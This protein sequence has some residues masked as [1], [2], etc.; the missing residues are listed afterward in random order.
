MT[1]KQTSKTDGDLNPSQRLYEE[2]TDFGRHANPNSPK[3][4]ADTDNTASPE[5]K[6]SSDNK[7]PDSRQSV[8]DGE[9]G[10]SFYKSGAG[11]QKFSGASGKLGPGA[12]KYGPTGGMVGLILFAFVGVGGG[13]TFL[14]GSLLINLKEVF[15]NDRSDATRTNRIFSRATISNAFR[16]TK[17]KATKTIG[18]VRKISTMSKERIKKFTE[19]GFTI[20]GDEIDPTTGKK[21]GSIQ[22]D[23][24]LEPNANSPPTDIV[25][26]HP[27][28]RG[29]ISEIDYPDGHSSVSGKDYFAH[30]D[31]NPSTLSEAEEAFPSKASFYLNKFF[32]K[33]LGKFGFSKKQKDFPDT[34][35]KHE[36]D[37]A[38]DEQTEEKAEVKDGE[39]PTVKEQ[40]DD[41]ESSD[42]RDHS[43]D[44]DETVDTAEE[45]AK[46]KSQ[47]SDDKDSSSKGNLL[48][49]FLQGVCSA[50]R[51]SNTI[52]AGVKIYHM[53]RLADFALMFLQAAD[54]IK[55]GHG[56]GPK[57]EYLSD[58][59]TSYEHNPTNPDGTPNPKYNL[60][61][62]DSD[63]YKT[64]AH[65]DQGALADF[66]KAF[67][68]GGGPVVQKT[69]IGKVDTVNST[70]EKAASKVPGTSGSGRRSM[71]SFCR[72]ANGN[73]GQ[74]IAQCQGVVQTGAAVGSE[75]GPLDGILEG[76]GQYM[77]ACTV[78]SMSPI[79]SSI[80]TKV[81]GCSTVQAGIEKLVSEAAST[82]IK[83]FNLK[84]VLLNIFSK[85][86]VNASTRGVDAGNA[87]AA[88]AGMMLSTSATGYGLHPS[89]AANNHQ[90]IQQYISYT[91][92]LEDKYVALDKYDG[93]QHPFDMTNQYS[94]LGSFIRS[95]DLTTV[96]P[97]SVFGSLNMLFSVFGSAAQAL[98]G[99]PANAL[100]NQPST[101]ADP[102]GTNKRYDYCNG[103]DPDTQDEDLAFI[104]AT[105]DKFCSIVGVSDVSELQFAEQQVSNP[106]SD[107][108]DNLA[109]WMAKPQS[110]TADSGL[111]NG[112]GSNC[113]KID[114][115]NDS[116]CK[117]SKKASIDPDTGK[118]T[119]DSQ[120]AK[121]LKY[122]TDQRAYPWGS[123]EEPYEQ[124]SNRDQRWYSGEECMYTAT[125]NGDEGKMVSNFR[126]WTNVC[127]QIGTLDGSTNCYTN[128]AQ[129]TADTSDS[130]CG[131]GT[132][133]S[134]YKCAL[135]FDSY[136][137]QMGAGHDGYGKVSWYQ[138]FKANPPT[139][140]NA[141]KF[142]CSS[143]VMASLVA[144]F[145]KDV[146]NMTAPS[147]FQDTKYWQSVPKDQAKQGDVVVFPAHVEIIKD[148]NPGS[149]TFT[150]FGAHTE[151][152]P[153]DQQIG[154]THY[155][156]EAVNV[157]TFRYIG[158]GVGSG[159]GNIS[160]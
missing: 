158:P 160:V 84:K 85:I 19:N 9:E 126:M 76:I 156:Y 64:A 89:S 27:D 34:D 35:E 60:T 33:V 137:Y 75:L 154:E 48:L 4:S 133:A 147:S 136:T 66:A 8:K 22:D 44:V 67:L 86:D 112:D 144:A 11:S 59:L 32:D 100:Y 151:N 21:I 56:L 50:Y 7:T 143:L 43:S 128:D 97:D 63:G 40:D 98:Q 37:N 101:A 103:D 96:Q 105:G 111:G 106:D 107:N 94:F 93:Q 122:C 121:Y 72:L 113:A 57:T 30:A 6:T 12:K 36:Q 145:G 118:P 79:G 13:T 102:N 68:L 148:N 38:F 140:P 83:V 120:Y 74:L 53:A 45:D 110:V 138:G 65:G 150:T 54:E 15:H 119:P 39:D 123:Q 141:L 20:K 116:G 31:L 159:T 134:V 92:P 139:D 14:G 157:G 17:A 88:G 142:D 41:G 82:V 71:K 58:N 70:L 117:S 153:V 55:D 130:N 146:P 129:Q 90:D 26:E 51:I 62:T 25:D 52:V 69:L 81:T 115:S 42:G 16:N 29:V 91:Q 132:T 149:Q 78:F 109:E 24:T 127:L 23:P 80:L 125:K 49:S 47:D 108:I 3:E 124:G 131:D 10:S 104:G 95:F 99:K 77:C 46:P 135:Q 152:A 87:I 5:D 114:G 28:A 73:I 1:E 155:S 2:E 18:I 61:A